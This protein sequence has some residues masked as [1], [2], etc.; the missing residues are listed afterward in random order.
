MK[1]KLLASIALFCGTLS[2]SAQ[3]PTNGLVS[4]WSFD[5]NLTLD[6]QGTYTLV[7][8]SAVLDS[9]FQALPST[10]AYFNGSANMAI[11]NAVFRPTTFS[12][13]TWFKKTGNVPYHTLANVRI[14]PSSS[15]FNSY[16]LC[17]GNSTSQKLTFFFTTN[18][19]NDL[20]IQDTAITDINIWTHVAVTCDYNSINSI[21]TF[22]MYV[23]GI[24]HAQATY[25]GNIIYGTNKPLTLGSV[26]GFPSGNS[27]NGKLDEFLFYNRVLTSTEVTNIFNGTSTDIHSSIAN[28]NSDIFLYPNPTSSILN[29]EVKEQTQINIVNVLGDVVK[30]ET[31]NG[32]CKLDI[33]ALNAGVYFI[34]DIRSGKA[35]KFIKE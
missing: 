26:S 25:S 22:K 3:V 6:S 13:S 35:I 20:S 28:Q 7:N 1:K 21:T 30:T 19:A 4:K 14:N 34:Q 5:G 8:N 12:I 17:I 32:V 10:A 2:L 33:S 15:P 24:L 29:I 27:L 9:G 23:N 31:I 11:N 18:N 16:N